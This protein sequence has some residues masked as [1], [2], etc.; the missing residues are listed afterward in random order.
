MSVYV[1]SRRI[2]LEDAVLDHA[3]PL[4]RPTGPL[5][6]IMRSM[7]HKQDLHWYT[8]L[9]SFLTQYYYLIMILHLSSTVSSH[10]SHVVSLYFVITNPLLPFPFPRPWNRPAIIHPPPQHM[11]KLPTRS[12]T[13]IGN[14]IIDAHQ[15]RIGLGIHLGKPVRELSGRSN[16][17]EY[18]RCSTYCIHI[19]AQEG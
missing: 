3:F 12:I 9:A 10:A 19:A 15:R 14:I 4:M 11:F 17:G 7:I 2:C 6:G 16:G 13:L 8:L 1:Q 5:S 18:G